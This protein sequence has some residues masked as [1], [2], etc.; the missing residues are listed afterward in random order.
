MPHA[1]HMTA[2]PIPRTLALTA[3]GDLEATVLRELPAG[4]RPVETHVVDGERARKRAYERIREEIADGR[5]CFVVCPLV[6][7]SEALQARAAT[8]ESERLRRTEFAE[9]RVELIHGQMPS[10]EKAGGDGVVRR[11]RGR[12]AGGHQRDRGGHRRA[13]RHRDADRGGRALRALAA[14]PAARARGPRRPRVDVHPVR[15]PQAAAAGGDGHRARR[16]QAGR[17]R[18]RAARRGRRA[19]HAPARAARAARGLAARGRAA[20]GARAPSGRGG[21]SPSED[22]AAAGG[23]GRALR[24]RAGPDPPSALLGETVDR[25]ML[26]HH[27]TGGRRPRRLASS[28]SPRPWPPLG[29]APIMQVP[30]GGL[31]L[32][33]R[34]EALVLDR[35]ARARRPPPTSTWPSR[36]PTARRVDRF[37]EAALAAGRRDNGEPG[38]AAR[39]TTPSTTGRSCSTSTATTSRPSATGRS[40]HGPA[41]GPEADQGALP[42]RP[43]GLADHAH[44]A[45]R[46]GGPAGVLLGRPRA[47]DP[48]RRGPPGRGRAGGGRP[49]RATCCWARWPPA[50][51]S[52]ARWWPTAMGIEASR[53][54]TVV[55]G[56]LDLAGHAG[57]QPRG[58]RRLR[59]DPAAL[60][61]RRARR[62]ARSS[63]ARWSRRPSATA[64]SCRR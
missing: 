51:R 31:R 58:A 23:G 18:P 19:G 52:P 44:R 21:W 64:R 63:C 50:R 33:R 22:D 6:E 45:G 46:P 29:V 5:Q 61:D 42:R 20:A 62:R 8:V 56:D 43:A 34:P 49:A 13:Q 54:E 26:D 60:R 24:L 32:R 57:H 17:D 3:Y 40:D 38:Q 11:R 7:E 27:G 9:Q 47:G 1:L 37:H 41:R 55:E 48:G 28:S 15:R 25:P 59:G 16:L 12:R 14:A 53:I 10:A 36:R 35:L 2:T 39:S 30:D 4:R